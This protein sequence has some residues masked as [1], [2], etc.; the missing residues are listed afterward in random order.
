MK[1]LL[2]LIIFLN[3]H[4][5]SKD[6]IFLN[7]PLL[8][9]LKLITKFYSHINIYIKCIYINTSNFINTM[10]IFLCK[11]KS[12]QNFHKFKDYANFIGAFRKCLIFLI[13]GTHVCFNGSPP[14]IHKSFNFNKILMH[15]LA[16]YYY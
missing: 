16:F 1:Q 13:I 10:S 15:F 8:Q 4:Q 9:K 2:R 7:R 11:E 14:P 6:Q 12:L 5:N 3:V